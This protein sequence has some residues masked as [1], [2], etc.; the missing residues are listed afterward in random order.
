MKKLTLILCVCAIAFTSILVSC[1]NEPEEYI[2][3]TTK[4]YNYMYSV[5][6]TVNYEQDY[7]PKDAVV[8]TTIN[9]T[10]T[11]ATGTAEW[12]ENAYDK[13]DYQKY[14]IKASGYVDEVNK[15]GSN[16]AVNTYKRSYL[17]SSDCWT[18]YKNDSKYY[19]KVKDKYVEVQLSSIKKDGFTYKGN[20]S[21]DDSD[22]TTV[23]KYTYY[24]DLTFSKLVK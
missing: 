23:N 2:D 19:I 7:G 16:A 9:R 10:F 4:Y 8:K 11:Q 12:S 17:I 15:E 13:S 5:T 3:T 20:F 14:T 21:V 24:F 6:G 22:T 18:V 1:K